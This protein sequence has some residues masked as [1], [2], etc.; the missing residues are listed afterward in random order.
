MGGAAVVFPGTVTALFL[1]VLGGTFL[2]FR[3]VL[4]RKEPG[5]VKDEG[6]VPTSVP[7]RFVRRSPMLSTHSRGDSISIP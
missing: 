2:A 7:V 4:D 5:A 3:L 6:L 1:V